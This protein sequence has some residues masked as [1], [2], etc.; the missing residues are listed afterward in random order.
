MGNQEYEERNKQERERE[1]QVSNEN[2]K[3][4][5]CMRKGRKRE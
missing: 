2:M 4:S 5:E 3:G 1:G